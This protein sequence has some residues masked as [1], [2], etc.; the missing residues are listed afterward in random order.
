M[1]RRHR[2]RRSEIKSK[3]KTAAAAAVAAA[4]QVATKDSS[5]FEPCCAQGKDCNCAIVRKELKEGMAAKKSDHE[6]AGEEQEQDRK[7][8]I[9]Q[10]T[11]QAM[12]KRII[13]LKKTR[14]K[15]VPSSV[16]Y[17]TLGE[18]MTSASSSQDLN[19]SVESAIVEGSAIVGGEVNKSGSQEQLIE[20][21]QVSGKMDEEEESGSLTAGSRM[22]TSSEASASNNN[23]VNS[24]CPPAQQQQHSDRVTRIKSTAFR[25]SDSHLNYNKTSP[26]V[27]STGSGSASSSNN[28]SGQLAGVLTRSNT[29][30][31]SCSSAGVVVDKKSGTSAGKVK[32]NTSS[33]YKS[34]RSVKEG[35]A[36]SR[37][38]FQHLPGSSDLGER[39]ANVDYVDPRR[40]FCVKASTVVH[41]KSEIIVSSSSTSKELKSV[42]QRDSVMSFTSSS[43]S[44]DEKGSKGGLVVRP[45]SLIFDRIGD[46]SYYE[47]DIDRCLEDASLFRDSAI[48][49]DD[50]DQR[51]T[52]V[53]VQRTSQSRT[54]SSSGGSGAVEPPPVPYKPKHVTQLQ[55]QKLQELQHKKLE[56][57]ASGGGARNPRTPGEEKLQRSFLYKGNT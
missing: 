53:I 56:R 20:S 19:D 16:F 50:N 45:E 30:S 7:P 43:D 22:S 13:N 17:A 32:K 39:I 26:I 28:N 14:S 49:S 1:E 18:I 36:T 40:L 34:F 31:S 2:Y 21:G 10:Y 29:I 35:E 42:Q 48:Y 27:P 33:L 4:A 3:N 9:N 6:T 25:A 11:T 52:T 37:M 23:I 8:P 41:R 55:Q 24:S 46:D 51:R 12:P 15:T 47:E 5:S 57:Q 44:V 38:S 54:S